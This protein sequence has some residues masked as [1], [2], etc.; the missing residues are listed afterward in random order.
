MYV[1]FKTFQVRELFD[2]CSVKT[3][4]TTYN[5]VMWAAATT[6]CVKGGFT[7]VMRGR[8]WADVKNSTIGFNVKILTS[9]ADVKNTTTRHQKVSRQGLSDVKTLARN[10]ML[11]FK[12]LL[13]ASVFSDI[14]LSFSMLPQ[15]EKKLTPASRKT[16]TQHFDAC[17]V[18]LWKTPFTRL[19][20]LHKLHVVH[21]SRVFLCGRHKRE[22][23]A[24]LKA[25]GVR[26]SLPVMSLIL[27]CPHCLPQGGGSRGRGV[28]VGEGVGGGGWG[29]GRGVEGGGGRGH[30]IHLPYTALPHG[31]SP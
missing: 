28:W 6:H 29:R 30:F 19:T 22:Q 16:W 15:C 26:S 3:L 8:F 25:T 31:A 13:P 7:L 2:V 27:P 4:A 9:D 5:R 1:R 14:S 24:V 20:S 18:T 21:R 11:V 12:I 17:Y 23:E 10:M